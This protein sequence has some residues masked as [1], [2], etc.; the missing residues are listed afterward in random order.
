MERIINE[1]L[2]W[3][4]EYNILDPNQNGFCKGRSCAD[5]LLK[6]TT[7]IKICIDKSEYMLIA[8]LDVT[9]AYDNVKYPTLITKLREKNARQK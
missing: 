4:A 9:S 8:F 5:N 3:W 7:D 6:I 2:I 1:R